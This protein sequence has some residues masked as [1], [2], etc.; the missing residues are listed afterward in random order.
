MVL[1]QKTAVGVVFAIV[2]YVVVPMHPI[3]VT[4]LVTVPIVGSHRHRATGVAPNK[5]ANRITRYYSSCLVS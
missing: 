1:L 2:P 3:V 5:I 4:P